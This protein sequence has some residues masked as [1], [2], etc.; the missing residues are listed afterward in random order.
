ML[1]FEGG[2][3][4]GTFFCKRAPYF[5]R[6]VVN[7]STGAMDVLDLVD[8]AP[9]P[10]EKV[11]VYRREGEASTFHLNRGAAGSGFFPSATYRY[12]TNG[13]DLRENKVWQAWC[14]GVSDSEGLNLRLPPEVM[15]DAE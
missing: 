6:A 10:N 15:G 1:K 14:M 9:E 2:P 12:M 4:E 3:V 7:E 8:D 5:L 13:E 11:Y